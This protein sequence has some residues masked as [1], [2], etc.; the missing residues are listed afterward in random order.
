MNPYYSIGISRGKEFATF[1]PTLPIGE[2]LENEEHSRQ[3]SDFAPISRQKWKGLLPENLEKHEQYTDDGDVLTIGDDEYR[4]TLQYGVET[5]A[6]CS[7]DDA[8]EN[9][10][11]PCPLY[12]IMQKSCTNCNSTYSHSCRSNNP[13]PMIDA[14]YSTQ[15]FLLASAMPPSPRS[16][17]YSPIMDFTEQSIFG[18]VSQ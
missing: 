6:L 8:Y 4:I 12:K 10:C 11:S 18:E 3:Y 13:Q 14:L 5:C 17:F 2:I 15:R 1:S 7:K 9:Y 16:I